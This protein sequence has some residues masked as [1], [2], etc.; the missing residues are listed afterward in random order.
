MIRRLAEKLPYL[1]WFATGFLLFAAFPPFGERMDAFFALA[2]AMF[3][4]RRNSPRKSFLCWFS[5]GLFFWVA[6]L[7]WMPAIVKN[8]GPWPLVLL[9]WFALSAY[10]AL[11]FG[12]FGWAS[13]TLWRWARPRAYVCR[14]AVIV[15]AEPLLWA[16]LELVRS[17]FGGGFAWNQLGVAPV[18]SGLG[19]PAVLGGV[20]LV[21]AA[22]VLV[23]GTF[24]SVAE[25]VFASYDA[26]A[27]AVPRWARS[28]ETILPVLLVLG[29]YS[30]ARPF[31]AEASGGDRRN[32]IFGLVQR[33]FPC[34]F[35][36]VEKDP[37]AVYS[38]LRFDLVSKLVAARPAD[39]SGHLARYDAFLLP[40]SALCESFK[41]GRAS[42]VNSSAAAEFAS[43]LMADGWSGSVIAGGSRIDRDPARLYNSLALYSD[44]PLQ[45][46]DKVHLVPFG[47]YIPGDKIFP[48]LQKMAPVGS[49]TAG[50]PKLLKIPAATGGVLAGPAIC[51]EDTDSALM[52]SHAAA[53]A[54]IL[55]FATNDSWFYGSCEPVQHAWQAV[56]RAVETGLP[57]VRTGNSGVTGHVLPD[58]SAT[59][60]QDASGKPLVDSPGAM[61]ANVTVRDGARQTPYVRLG[62]T[63]LFCA[64]L[65]LITA[66]SV[67][68]YKS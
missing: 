2:P 43:Q 7:S 35:L 62:D 18:N 4:A 10:C 59:W 55:V 9:G 56:A 47:E 60:L 53:G 25:R 19:A 15:V 5:N 39:P 41:A 38:D 36:P 42:L 48:S 37:D 46:Y 32:V 33:N 11:Y 64:F 57:V 16:G 49:C 13:A 27:P 8:D 66:I 67:I 58:G 29:L 50:E 14:L 31:V 63:P 54:Q 51:F 6:T 44:G 30:A 28:V 26:N 52:R 40:E 21:S 20:Y 45:V 3:F 1:F 65:L 24:A 68:K 61:Y 22:V 12:A 23:N 17:R 34:A